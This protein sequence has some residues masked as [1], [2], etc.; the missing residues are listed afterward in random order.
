MYL[1]KPINFLNNV[2][3]YCY[4]FSQLCVCSVKWTCFNCQ[5]FQVQL[6][7]QRVVGSV[8]GGQWVLR[9]WSFRWWSVDFIKPRKNHVWG[10]DFALCTLVNVFFIIPILIFIWLPE[11]ITRIFN[12]SWR[13]I[14]IIISKETNREI[15]AT[16]SNIYF[17]Y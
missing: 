10:S 16:S 3:K 8:V 13:Y 14:S 2:P 7:I 1:W 17:N 5:V 6:L 15:N 11:V 9:R 4:M 12:Y